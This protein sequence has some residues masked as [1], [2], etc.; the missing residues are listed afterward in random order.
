MPIYEFF[1]NHCKSKFEV[2]EKVNETNKPAC[3]VCGEKRMCKK[4]I[5]CS[6]FFLKG[7]CWA[8][9]GYSKSTNNSKE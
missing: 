1:C 8:K 6:N 9:D 2:F 4:L 3:P 7:N 5:S